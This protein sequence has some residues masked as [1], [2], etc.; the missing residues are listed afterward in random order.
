MTASPRVLF[1]GFDAGDIHLILDWARAGTLPMLGALLDRG[2]QGTVEGLPG[3]WVGSTW[4]NFATGV[5]PARHGFH[6]S[7]Q[8]RPGSYDFF[9][10]VPFALFRHEPFW[11][12]LG[13]A[14]R[15]VAVL[16]VP[17]AGPSADLNGIQLAEW[18]NHDAVSPFRTWP[19]TLAAEVEASFG[20][21]PTREKCDVRRDARQH[22]AFRDRLLEGVATKLALTKHLLHRERWDFFAQ[23][24]TEGHCA[25]HQCWHIHDPTHSYHDAAV[26]QAVGD[27]V[28]ESY[29]AIDRAIGELLDE[30][31]RD[32]TVVLFASHGMEG[33]TVYFSLD[34]ILLR[35]GV[36]VAPRPNVVES[37][38]GAPYRWAGA[39][40][41]ALLGPVRDRL[42]SA[43]PAPPV[44]DPATSQ[45]FTVHD[46]G[47]VG[48]IRVNIVGREPRGLVEP[49][50]ALDAFCAALTRDL[51]AITNLETGTPVVRRVIRTAERY[52]GPCCDDLPD[53]LVEWNNDE[54][55][56]AIGSLK[57]GELRDP[58]WH[59]RTGGHHSAGLVIAAGPGIATGRLAQPVSIV[60]LAPTLAALLDV[61][62]PDGDGRVIPELLGGRGS[63]AVGLRARG[64]ASEGP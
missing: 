19:P 7:R 60:D 24:F 30:V 18:G 64:E 47:A 54:P 12:V 62:L 52:Q 16:D 22:A 36:A 48:S 40:V 33:R 6:A 63:L 49:G 38:L 10:P 25:G 41:R 44:I 31:G 17:L 55:L 14:G 27:P 57:I 37:L 61:R 42:R 5:S 34:E 2:L 43:F 3:F 11:N 23:V 58:S 59:C 8:I 50:P 21:H 26:R 9:V 35:L 46:N 39:T 45:C 32:T 28:V 1:L 20:L 4:P 53:L 13:R 15:R 56:T 51:T 29:V